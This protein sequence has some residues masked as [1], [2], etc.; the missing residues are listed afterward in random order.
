VKPVVAPLEV[1]AAVSVE[2]AAAAPV[3]PVAPAAPAPRASDQA[4]RAGGRM[5]P[6]L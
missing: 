1:A 4:C 5:V 6:P 2:A 3:K